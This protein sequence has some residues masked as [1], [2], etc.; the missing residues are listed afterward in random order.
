MHGAGVQCEVE[1][2]FIAQRQWY[3]G[4]YVLGNISNDSLVIR[5]QQALTNGVDSHNGSRRLTGGLPATG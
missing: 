5:R 1:T 3:S 4:E 2:R